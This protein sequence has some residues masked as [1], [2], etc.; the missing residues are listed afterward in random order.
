ME[1]SPPKSF[2]PLSRI[3]L[4][5]IKTFAN[6]FLTKPNK[7][8]QIW[9]FAEAANFIWCL[10]SEIFFVKFCM[11]V[12]MYVLGFTAMSC[13]NFCNEKWILQ[14]MG[15]CNLSGDSDISLDQCTLEN[16]KVIFWLPSLIYAKLFSYTSITVL[17]RCQKEK[18]VE[19]NSCI[20]H[21]LTPVL[22]PWIYI[23][24]TIS[25]FCHRFLSA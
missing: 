3:N 19:R 13:R 24:V 5:Q 17:Q 9:H 2:F 8:L 12:Y 7:P 4:L 20:M 25:L 15:Q 21:L 14:N 1:W 6:H 11:L 18:S 23:A 10:V 16:F 22:T